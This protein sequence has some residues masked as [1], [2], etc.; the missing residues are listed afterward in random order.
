MNS[1]EKVEIGNEKGYITHL[2]LYNFEILKITFTGWMVS[3]RL[4]VSSGKE[5]GVA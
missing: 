2:C 3:T 5:N 1:T 4:V